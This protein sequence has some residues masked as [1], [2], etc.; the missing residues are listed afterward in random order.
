[1]ALIVVV[2]ASATGRGRYGNLSDGAGLMIMAA[3]GVALL[4]PITIALRVRR[5]DVVT[6]GVFSDYTTNHH[7]YFLSKCEVRVH[8]PLFNRITGDR[9]LLLDRLTLRGFF[10]ANELSAVNGH[11]RHLSLMNPTS[12]NVLSALGELNNI[13]SGAD[14]K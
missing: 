8:R 12:R 4:V 10:N 9:S 3:L 13:R 14:L 2:F 11:F 5:T 7:L 6:T 1:M